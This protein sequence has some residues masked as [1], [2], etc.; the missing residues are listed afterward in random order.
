MERNAYIRGETVELR[1][2]ELADADALHA[3]Y[4]EPRTMQ[5]YGKPVCSTLDESRKL[6]AQ[7]LSHI[8]QGGAVRWAICRASDPRVVGSIGF[9]GW[10]RE[11]ETAWLSYE[12][13]PQERGRRLSAE[14]GKLAIRY[15]QDVMGLR[16]IFAAVDLD[17]RPSLRIVERLGFQRQVN[18]RGAPQSDP[19]GRGVFE[20][21]I[22]KTWIGEVLSI[23]DEITCGKLLDT[24]SQ[25]LSQRLSDLGVSVRF[26]TSIG[27]RLE[28]YAEALRTASSRADM[29]VCSGGLGPT[30]DDLTSMALAQ[31]AG[32]E[33]EFD[34]ESWRQIQA[35]FA[36][37]NRPIAPSNRKQA[38]RPVGS[39]AIFNPNGTAPGI[40][41]PM[42]SSGGRQVRIF[43]LPGVPAEMREMWP[44]V[45][46]EI[47]S[48]VGRR[49]FFQYSLHCFG[50]GESDIEAM[51]PAEIMRRERDPLVGITASQATI[52]L[53]VATYG[54]SLESCRIF[55]Q[56]TI[57]RLRAALGDYVYGKQDETLAS[58][59]VGKLREMGASVAIVDLGLCGELYQSLHE[60]DRASET[61]RGSLQLDPTSLGKIFPN[62]GPAITLDDAGLLEAA[63][64]VRKLFGASMGLAVSPLADITAPSQ[65]FRIAVATD[66]RKW[67]HELSCAGHPAIRNTRATKGVLNALRLEL[68]IV[69]QP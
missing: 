22:L 46:C 12:I 39:R 62:I 2:I 66:T 8:S 67:I 61:V 53:R 35:I 20:L 26:H 17:N 55:A 30:E 60:F 14:A 54:D 10:D 49:V 1:P 29:I 69:K 25:W 18:G 41:L 9:H 31:H 63:A 38:L 5:F 24:N 44:A 34:E 32:V 23:G 48:L 21:A 43:A 64:G 52:S 47:Q 57:D 51:I 45:A 19:H 6:V 27:D 58:V 11:Q 59:A 50:A 3:I 13:T 68:K 28:D 33:Q 40:D 42:R 36:K 15:A 16:H 37:R 56:P 4:C 65:T 7:M